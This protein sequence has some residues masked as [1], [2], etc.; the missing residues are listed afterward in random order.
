MSL[1]CSYLAM[2]PLVPQL[3]SDMAVPCCTAVFSILRFLGY[4]EFQIPHMDAEERKVQETNP[5]A[6]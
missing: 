1:S 6:V 4:A 2:H 5:A 3:N